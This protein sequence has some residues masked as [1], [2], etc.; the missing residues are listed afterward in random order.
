MKEDR[1]IHHSTVL[2]RLHPRD[3]R[4]VNRLFDADPDHIAAELFDDSS[5]YYQV[6]R[7][8]IYSLEAD[9]DKA[10]DMLR[11]AL[12]ALATVKRREE[13]EHMLTI[14]DAPSLK[15]QHTA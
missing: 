1:G 2:Q 3:T 10:R 12:L 14:L 11:G 7:G 6:L 5:I 4:S 9:D 13:I 15:E 8:K